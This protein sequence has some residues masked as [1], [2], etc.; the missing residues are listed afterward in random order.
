[1]LFESGLKLDVLSESWT[2]IFE[3]GATSDWNKTCGNSR[4]QGVALYWCCSLGVEPVDH[5][6]LKQPPRKAKDPIITRQLIINVII[7]AA[8]IVSGTL[9]VFWREVLTL[10]INLLC[11]QSFIDPERRF[12]QKFLPALPMYTITRNPSTI[13]VCP[14]LY[15]CLSRSTPSV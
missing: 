11:R 12:M 7:S 2:E 8:I 14:R 9:W 4:R 3:I 10:V 5:D 13:P 15:V 6:V 1:V